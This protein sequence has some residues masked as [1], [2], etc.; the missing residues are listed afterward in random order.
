MSGAE[1]QRRYRLAKGGLVSIE[2]LP[3]VAGTL[4]TLRQRTGSNT[5]EVVTR[6]LALLER[7]VARTRVPPQKRCGGG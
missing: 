7:E 6:A 1:R 5:S 2:L 3:S 4:R